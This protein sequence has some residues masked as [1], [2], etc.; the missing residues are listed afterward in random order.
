[1][2]IDLFCFCGRCLASHARA[3]THTHYTRTSQRLRVVACTR[4][5]IKGL[6][7]VQVNA[8]FRQITPDSILRLPGQILMKFG[9]YQNFKVSNS[10]PQMT[11]DT[12]YSNSLTQERYV[13]MIQHNI[14]LDKTPPVVSC[15]Y[16]ISC[17]QVVFGARHP[18]NITEK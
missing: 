18:M 7:T 5:C 10:F 17:T 12:S 15:V 13:M 1:M 11:A 6:V 3:H 8:V 2:F 4:C 9:V 14:P 16:C